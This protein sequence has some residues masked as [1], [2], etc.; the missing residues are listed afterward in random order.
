M[1]GIQHRQAKALRRY[2]LGQSGDDERRA[3][4]QRL[5]IDPQHLDDLTRA[6][7]QL[8]DEYAR[9]ELDALEKESFESL[10]LNV[11]ERREKIAFAQAF[12]RYLARHPLAHPEAVP[13]GWWRS[14]AVGSLAA[15]VVLL[16]VTSGLMYRRIV[17]TR[18][19][20]AHSQSQLAAS[21]SRAK[22]ISDQL[23]QQQTHTKELQQELTAIQDAIRPASPDVLTLKLI[24]GWVRGGELT[25]VA[26]VSPSIKRLRFRFLFDPAE[27][28][29][30]ERYRVQVQTVGGRVFWAR[31][32]SPERLDAGTRSVSVTI[33]ATELPAGDYLATLTGIASGGKAEETKSYYFRIAKQQRPRD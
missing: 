23:N 28:R 27:E 29:S 30:D 1:N 13:P 12:N 3:L 19:D 16:A 10:F 8:I 6:E 21:E 20:L 32:S 26:N 4:E 2:L 17:Q 9:G 24:S 18:Q 31:N 33:P 25:P 11:P 15:A 5:M 14:A 22:T 7:E